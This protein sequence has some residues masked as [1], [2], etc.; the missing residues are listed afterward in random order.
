MYRDIHLQ[1]ENKIKDEELKNM[2]QVQRDLQLQFLQSQ[3][4]EEHHT[5]KKKGKKNWL[6]DILFN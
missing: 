4:Q 3:V 2:H 5:K 6:F 1:N